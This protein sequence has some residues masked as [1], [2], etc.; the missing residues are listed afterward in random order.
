MKE[1]IGD[2][3]MNLINEQLAGKKENFSTKP[4]VP[5]ASGPDLSKVK[6]SDNAMNLILEQS[7][8]I[9][10]NKPAPVQETKAFTPVEQPKKVNRTPDQIVAEF[11]EIVVK[12]RAL[13][14][15]MTT[16]GMIGANQAGPVR[17]GKKKKKLKSKAY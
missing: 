3:A 2:F 17:V 1:S 13:L 16:C 11:A 6:V 12:A 5:G 15:E 10:A 8:G 7:F 4:V 9:K 14:Q